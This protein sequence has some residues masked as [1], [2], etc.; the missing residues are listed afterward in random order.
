[1]FEDAP[2][3]VMKSKDIRPLVRAWFDAKG[4]KLDEGKLW[5]RMQ[6]CFKYDPNNNRPRYLGLK[7]RVKG[8]PR[9]AVVAGKEA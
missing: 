7:A 8:P 9:L 1:M 3:G 4:K 6:E 5:A 2:G